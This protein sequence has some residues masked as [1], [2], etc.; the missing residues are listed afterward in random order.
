MTERRHPRGR[1]RS[2]VGFWSGDG[3]GDCAEGVAVDDQAHLGPVT[4]MRAALGTIW[5]SDPHDAVLV[6]VGSRQ[7]HQLGRE[8]AE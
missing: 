6:P 5:S 8:L 2:A 7:P 4:S 1:R 3:I